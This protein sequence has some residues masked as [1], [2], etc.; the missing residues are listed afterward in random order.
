M[1]LAERQAELF[2]DPNEPR[3]LPRGGW[4]FWTLNTARPGGGMTQRVYRLHQ[5]EWVLKHA[6]PDRDTYMSQ[7]F[8]AKPT[9]RALHLAFLTHAYVDID[10]YK[11]PVPPNPGVA[12]IMIRLF[13]N[14]EG[15]PEPSLIVFSGRGVYLKWMWSSPLPRA[16][17]GRAVAVNKALVRRFEEWGAD[18]AAVDVSRVLR[19]VGTTNSR[20][21]ERA[22][23]LWQAERDG[24][25]LTYD[26]DLF[27]DEILPYSLEQIR[28]F[29]EAAQARKA[30]VRVLSQEKARRQ[31]QREAEQARKGGQKVFC[32]EDW[33]WGVV[34]DLRT[35]AGLRWADGI[36]RPGSLDLFGHIG[37][38]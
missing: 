18:P 36:V 26:F 30:E 2:T 1:G 5:L 24:Q 20:S 4:P 33:H 15:I 19:V 38:C 27:A 16:A 21:G 3:I 12:G 14:D 6:A 32:N 34:E 8:F 11:L 28:G 10:L 31:A 7:A 25:P 22:E 9:R 23:I 37:A 13:C 29:R 17:A 35:L